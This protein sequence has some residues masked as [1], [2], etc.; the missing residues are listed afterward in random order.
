[1]GRL[2]NGQLEWDV[3]PLWSVLG[4]LTDVICGATSLVPCEYH[5]EGKLLCQGPERV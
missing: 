5:Q 4:G 2:V 3:L 1:M